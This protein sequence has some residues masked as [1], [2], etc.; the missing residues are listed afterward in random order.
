MKACP[1]G[2]R[3]VGPCAGERRLVTW[4]AAFTGYALCDERAQVG[5]EAYLSA[6]TFG[7]DF[8]EYLTRTGSTRGYAGGCWSPWLWWDIDRPEIGNAGAGIAAALADTRTLCVNLSDRFAL[9]DDALLVFYSGSKGFH[10]GLPTAAWK[11]D[12]SPDFNKIVRR[13]CEGFAAAFPSMR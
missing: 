6:F 1:Y 12:A 11:P 7:E 4:H 5:R 8:R 10:V 9:A 2:F 3:I 13:F